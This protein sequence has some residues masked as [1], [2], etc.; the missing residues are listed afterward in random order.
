MI[1]YDGGD[2]NFWRVIK[3]RRKRSYMVFNKLISYK[4]FYGK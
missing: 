2:K 1:G 3:P 4:Y